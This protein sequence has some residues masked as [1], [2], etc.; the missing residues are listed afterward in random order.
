MRRILLVIV[1]LIVVN[2]LLPASRPVSAGQEQAPEV[3]QVELKPTA[4]AEQAGFKTTG[5]A[6]V[7]KKAG[8]AVFSMKLPEGYKTPDKT[9]F[10]GWVVHSGAYEKP[11]TL[12]ARSKHQQFGPS[13]ANKTLAVL[14]DAIPFWLTMGAM[15]D[16]GQGTLMAAVRWPNYNFGPYDTLTVTIET[17]GNKAPWDPRPGAPFL[18]GLFSEAKPYT[19]P[20][21]VE[22]LV[23][24]MPDLSSA[25]GVSLR[26]T[27]LGDAAGFKGITG[28]AFLL[29]E[30][31][32]AEIEVKLGNSKIPEGAVLEAFIADGG[33]LGNF[34]ASHAHE[35]D[36]Q[37]G[38]ADANAYI[39]TIADAIPF[40]TSLGVLKADDQGVFRAQIRWP[41]YAFRVYTVVMI[42]VEADGNKAPWNPRPGTPIL[43][44]A[45]SP[46]TNVTAL[47]ALPPKE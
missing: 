27:K 1:S 39:H 29:I 32:A 24:P 44:G 12:A 22:K 38:P 40:A 19:E 36:N 28:R 5:T 2:A 18:R 13:Y 41:S 25:Q 6:I 4:L 34:G 26:P 47:M 3:V 11:E 10:E 31:G 8:W 45:I 17:D 15:V 37:F 43:V 21:D 35:A 33:K 9:V 20:V 16:D 7:N 42:T 23:G 46:D 14:T 30:Q